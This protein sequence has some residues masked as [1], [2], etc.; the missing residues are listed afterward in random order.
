[1]S[2]CRRTQVR[3]FEHEAVE[4]K[5]TWVVGLASSLQTTRPIGTQPLLLRSFSFVLFSLSVWVS[6]WGQRV[7]VCGG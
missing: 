6:M 3:V 5:P 2:L 7:C 4:W 1:M